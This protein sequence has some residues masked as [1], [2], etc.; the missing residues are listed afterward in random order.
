MSKAA[1]T[2][3]R[4]VI[5]GHVGRADGEAVDYARR[6][7]GLLSLARARQL[8]VLLGYTLV[9]AFIY[10]AA[11][12]IPYGYVDDYPL[13]LDGLRHQFGPD[14][15]VYI[16]GGRP[17]AGGLE[18]LSHNFLGGMH[19]L[20]YLRLLGIFGIALLAWLLFRTLL[21]AGM[22]RRL[23]LAIPVFICTLPTFQVAAGWA[24]LWDA[25]YA[26]C[27]AGGALLIADRAMHMPVGRR[28]VLWIGVSVALVLA[29]LLVYQPAAMMYWVFAA[30]IFFTRDIALAQMVRRLAAFSAIMLVA[31]ALA[32]GVFLVLPVLVYGS[33]PIANPA[34][35]PVLQRAHLISIG[36]IPA[37][38]IWFVAY[39]L[40]EA[41]NLVNLHWSRIAALIACAFTFGGLWLH[42]SGRPVERIAKVAIAMMFIPLSFLANLVVTENLAAYRTQMALAPLL[43]FYMILA[44]GAWARAR[45]SDIT[46][47]LV[48][49][50]VF[51]AVALVCAA[52]AGATIT[53]YV[54]VPQYA[55]Y[56]W[57]HDQLAA[58]PL[59]TASIIYVIPAP[60]GYGDPPVQGSDE[61][62][63][64]STAS[65]FSRVQIVRVALHEIDPSLDALPVELAPQGGPITPPAGS[66][67]IDMRQAQTSPIRS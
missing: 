65:Q 62:G 16:Q 50:G 46:R 61:F 7:R 5:P 54:A 9:F 13:L 49:P 53:R 21:S 32:Y 66:I 25:V 52:T 18:F 20:R 42:F 3:E 40:S 28:R 11:W 60:G 8:D 38:L 63:I 6:L 12:I 41:L 51:W 22:Q 48:L 24:I 39:P 56:Q 4:T 19:D 33:R 10:A 43:A 15:A 59:S 57:L 35:G 27:A 47:Q 36:D 55:E 44:F 2:A 34:F 26:A 58:A 64:P 30:I 14:M 23:A 17:I 1:A 45:Q 67:V 29:A 37:K 31:L